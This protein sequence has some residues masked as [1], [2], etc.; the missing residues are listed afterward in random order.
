MKF[1]PSV[2]EVLSPKSDVCSIP[3]PYVG[4][5]QAETKSIGRKRIWHPAK[6]CRTFFPA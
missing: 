4:R 2:G 6:N 5:L 3:D 1:R